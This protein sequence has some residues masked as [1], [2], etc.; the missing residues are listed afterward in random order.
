MCT[1]TPKLHH[2]Y[3]IFFIIGTAGALQVPVIGWQPLQSL[4]QLGPLGIFVV[5]Q[6]IYIADMIAG[7]MKLS[8]GARDG[9]RVTM[10]VA[11][12]AIAVAIL[13]AAMESGY[14]GPVSARVRGLF[15]KHT[16]TGNP[17]V[18][19]VVSTHR[20]LISRDASER[21]LLMTG[22]A[23]SHSYPR[24]L[25]IFPHHHVP[26]SYRSGISRDEEGSAY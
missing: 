26:R 1:D 20:N 21:L 6:V 14:L 10:V 13:F 15:I 8:D 25:E 18:D 11:G 19:S 5:L 3:S 23:P 7:M 4:E 24:L 22:R 17:L 16:K 2:A 12:A 9:L